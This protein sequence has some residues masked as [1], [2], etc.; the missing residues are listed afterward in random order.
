MSG[1][2]NPCSCGCAQE[3]LVITKEDIE[4]LA[5]IGF[6]KPDDVLVICCMHSKFSAFYQMTVLCVISLFQDLQLK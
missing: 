3:D 4:V 2:C 1:I 6:G 5:T